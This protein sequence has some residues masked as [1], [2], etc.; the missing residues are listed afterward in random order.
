[1]NL[2]QYRAKIMR[3]IQGSE[4]ARASGLFIN[5]FVVSHR[6]N[7]LIGRIDGNTHRSFRSLAQGYETA[8]ASGLFKY[9]V[10]IDCAIYILIGRID[11]KTAPSF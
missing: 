3:W 1:M 5:I 9:V 6:I 4:T 8:G 7:I 11:G 2:L 10:S